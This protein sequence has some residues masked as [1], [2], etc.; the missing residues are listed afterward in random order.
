M[1]FDSIGYEAPRVETQD[2]VLRCLLE[3]RKRLE[4]NWCQFNGASLT[5]RIGDDYHCV[6]NTVSAVCCMGP[7]TQ[8]YLEALRLLGQ[9]LPVPS[10]DLK[11]V[12]YFNDTRSHAEVL[13]LVD[14]AIAA[15]RAEV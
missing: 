6:V 9:A 14:R 11:D 8:T 13:A 4:T 2:D 3:T 7:N 15:R 12:F 5:F 10:G 1:P